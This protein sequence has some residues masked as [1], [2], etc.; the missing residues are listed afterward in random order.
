MLLKNKSEHRELHKGEMSSNGGVGGLSL[1]PYPKEFDNV[2][3]E[4]IRVKYNKTC[5]L[6]GLKEYELEGYFK[7]LTIHHI[8]YIKNDC[9]EYNLIPL[10]NSCNVKTSNGDREFWTELISKKVMI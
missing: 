4:K 1:E 3:K 5:Q 7:K 2:L 10:C 8:N 6:C 9:T